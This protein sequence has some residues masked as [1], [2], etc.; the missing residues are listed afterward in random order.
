VSDTTAGN[1]TEYGLILQE[2]GPQ[3]RA[4][5]RIITLMLNYQYGI[6]T[7]TA[8]TRTE[9]RQ[10]LGGEDHIR[11]VFAIDRLPPDPAAATE[12]SQEGQ[13]PLFWLCHDKPNNP[14]SPALPQT[15]L[16]TWN[17]LFSRLQPA[18]TETFSACGINRLWDA[19][20]SKKTKPADQHRILRLLQ[21]LDTLPTLPQ[22]ILRIMRLISDPRSTAADLESALIRDPAVVHKLLR[23][24]SSPVFSGH[25]HTGA[26]TLKEAIVRLG[27]RKVGALVQ[28]IKLINS[29][30]KPQES[31]FDLK[32]FWLHSVACAVIADQLYTSG[33]LPLKATVQFDD[34]WIAA[35]L[36]DIGKLFLGSFFWPYFAAVSRRFEQE[37]QPS[38]FR[39]AEAHFGDIANHE[40]IGRLLLIKS[41]MP[42]GL[43]EA[44]ATHHS[45]GPTPRPLVCLIH[46]ADNLCKDLGQ[47][48][49]PESR[50]CYNPAV[51]RAMR[52]RPTDT[53]ALLE[54]LPPDLQNDID[55]FVGRCF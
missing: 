52:L 23:A 44:V 30:V 12:L 26:W 1:A 49:L 32:R 54:S 22:V 36:H 19:D 18:V 34:Y 27:R 9:A 31:G 7:L 25:G 3:Q 50:A 40:H 42:A 8:T 45:G 5:A 35:L 41:K 33:K 53:Q 39:R 51:L 48:Y 4:L 15:H 17:E 24:I 38:D 47:G 55:E 37:E 29:F 16:F 14:T 46:L 43:I 2:D 11:A 13:R 20:P 10:V 6:P 21:N 28:Q